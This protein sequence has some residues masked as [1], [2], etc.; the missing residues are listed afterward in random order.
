MQAVNKSFHT[1]THGGGLQTSEFNTLCMAHRH[2]P[3][4]PCGPDAAGGAAAA[5]L[6]EN[7]GDDNGDSQECPLHQLIPALGAPVQCIHCPSRIP[8]PLLQHSALVLN[9][10]KGA[11]VALCSRCRAS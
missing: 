5:P 8:W 10:G 1:M 7:D 6:G 2:F 9:V 4:P 3:P 11:L